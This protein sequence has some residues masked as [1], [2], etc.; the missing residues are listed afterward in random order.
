MVESNTTPGGESSPKGQPGQGDGANTPARDPLTPP[1]LPR[2]PADG[3]EKSGGFTPPPFAP[4]KGNTPTS[5]PGKGNQPIDGVGGGNENANSGDRGVNGGR[6]QKKSGDSATKQPKDRWGGRGKDG[7]RASADPVR[8]AKANRQRNRAGQAGRAAAKASGGTKDDQRLAE[9]LGNDLSDVKNAEGLGNKAKAARDAGEK[10]GRMVLNKKT[11]GASE[12]VLN[13]AAGKATVKVLRKVAAVQA[14]LPVIMV[15]ILVATVVTIVTAVVGGTASEDGVPYALDGDNPLALSEEYLEAYQAAGRQYGVPWTVLAGIAQVATEQGR[16]APSDVLDYGL[17]VDR[18]PDRA[19]IGATGQ[20]AGTSGKYSPPPGTAIAVLGDSFV[21]GGAIPPSL[22]KEL[23]GYKVASSG[24]DGAMIDDVDPDVRAALTTGTPVVVVQ[25]GVNDINR[26]VAPEVYRTQVQGLMD[27]ASTS[28]CFVWVNLQEFYGGDYG[29]VG[30]RAKRFNQ[31]LYEEAASR[32]WVSIADVATPLAVA[33]MQGPDG[34]HLSALGARTWSAAVARTVRGCVRGQGELLA[35][36][37]DGGSLTDPA[38]QRKT[39]S[40]QPVKVDPSYGTYVCFGGVCGPNPQIGRHEGAPRGVFL[41]T[42]EFVG[43]EGGGRSPDDV[44]DAADMLAEELA[45]IRDVVLDNDLNNQFDGWES[46]PLAARA[47]WAQVVALAPVVL[48]QQGFVATE[49]ESGP[50]AGPQGSPYVWPIAN[51]EALGEFGAASGDEG[52]VQVAGMLLGFA[53]GDEQDRTVRTAGPGVVDEIGSDVDG[54]TVV[55]AHEGRFST[56]YAHLTSLV[57]GLVVG[58]EIPAG[59]ALGEIQSSL[60]F[61]ARVGGSPR[62]PRLYVADASELPLAE[63]V[64]KSVRGEPETDPLLGVPVDPCTNLRLASASTQSSA[65]TLPSGAGLSLPGSLVMPAA[66]VRPDKLVDTFSDCRDGCQ[67]RH[68]GIDIIIPVG[69][70]LVAVVDATVFSDSAGG[71]PCPTTGLTG[72]GVT[73][74]DSSGNHYYYGHMDQVR[75]S[76]GQKVAAG[77]IIGTSGATGNACVSV[78][79]LHFS[80]NEN[81][82]KVV[83]PYPVLSSARPLNINDFASALAAGEAS[84]LLGLNAL[85]GGPEYVVAFAT[86]FGGLVEDDPDAGTFPGAATGFAPDTFSGVSGQDLAARSPVIWGVIQQT[87]PAEQWDNAMRVAE[88]ES[89]LDPSA[90]SDPNSNGSVDRGLFQFNDGDGK[91]SGTLQGWL[92]RTGEDPKNFAKALDPYWSARAAAAKV[93]AD[94]GWGAWSCAHT[95][96]GDRTY[97]LSIVSLSPKEIAS[98]GKI[99]DYSWQQPGDGDTSRRLLSVNFSAQPSR[100]D[101]GSTPSPQ[102]YQ[103][104]LS[105]SMVLVTSSLNGQSYACSGAVVE[106]S[107]AVVTAAHCVVPDKSR[108]LAHSI[109]VGQVSVPDAKTGRIAKT[110][111]PSSVSVRLDW[112]DP[113]AWCGDLAATAKVSLPSCTARNADVA[114]LWFSET[115]PMPGLKLDRCNDPCSLTK[116]PSGD[117]SL[118][119][120][121]LTGSNGVIVKTLPSVDKKVKSPTLVLPDPDYPIATAPLARKLTACTVPAN[122]VVSYSNYSVG[123]RCGMINGASGGVLVD[124]S[125]GTPRIVGVNSAI[126]SENLWNLVVPFDTLSDAFWRASTFIP[127]HKR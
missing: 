93:K 125:S 56:R 41:L 36:P 106:G 26:D 6:D 63:S 68:Q 86:F 70:P 123:V 54:F 58:L 28:T 47:L 124:E 20:N 19:P 77:S 116:A 109:A 99:I 127:E 120:F 8:D 118:L 110:F 80:I 46:D 29:Y 72:K 61:E 101:L 115:L 84:R 42:P 91:L 25:A 74:E 83:N 13:T 85:N 119:G 51:P 67:R 102:L 15:A 107:R 112:E 88:C 79:H 81:T 82:S 5:P 59:T 12:K 16:Y 111:K 7:A 78:P 100:D 14:M 53:D 27:A 104:A 3:A 48:P 33:G 30:P 75:V 64:T 1:S 126:Y 71:V 21:A 98:N 43:K 66:G 40:G 18:A 103:G 96:Y 122:F 45:D 4:T 22:V 97:G 55:V 92:T 9:G 73:L 105:K 113:K 90:V 89:G 94:G 34:L 87:F 17:L 65:V 35:A 57:D 23:Q 32:P 117:L 49:C 60:L 10:A 31:V 2:P 44:D 69:T 114:I 76:R 52:R 50:L 24:E 11:G 121:Q 95:P 62:N 108:R 38:L 39:A 37:P